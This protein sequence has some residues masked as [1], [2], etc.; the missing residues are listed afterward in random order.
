[1]YVEYIKERATV[2]GLGLAVVA[3]IVSASPDDLLNG[4]ALIA[5]GFI[6]LTPLKQAHNSWSRGD[7]ERW[8]QVAVP[9]VTWAVAILMVVR[10]ALSDDFAKSLEAFQYAGGLVG[11]FLIFLLFVHFVPFAAKKRKQCPECLGAAHVD[12]RICANCGFRWKP[13][14]PGSP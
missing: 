7:R 4:L 14:L 1:M 8:I 5:V 9:M 6:L 12:A 10:A 2:L 11:A 3:L 13:P